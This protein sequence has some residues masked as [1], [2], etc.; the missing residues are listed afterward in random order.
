MSSCRLLCLAMV[1]KHSDW[2][3]ASSSYIINVL[4]IQFIL[5]TYHEVDIYVTNGPIPQYIAPRATLDCA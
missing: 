2:F 5:S 4:E 3:N 1:E